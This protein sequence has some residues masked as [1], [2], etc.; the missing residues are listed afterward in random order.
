MT[1]LRCRTRACPH[2]PCTRRQTVVPSA[3]RAPRREMPWH[4]MGASAKHH[5]FGQKRLPADA[6]SRSGNTKDLH[7]LP[8]TPTKAP[9]QESR[10]VRYSHFGGFL[11]SRWKE[12]SRA[13][14]REDRRRSQL[15]SELAWLN[16]VWLHGHHPWPADC[17]YLCS[18]RLMSQTPSAGAAAHASL[19]MDM[20]A[21][22]EA[23]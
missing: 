14:S 22:A 10:A 5:M 15:S 19:Q 4:I 12:G 8:R 20:P 9:R 23:N 17:V 18:N 6:I 7:H 3:P 21:T 16:P 2:F 11:L 13:S 1:L